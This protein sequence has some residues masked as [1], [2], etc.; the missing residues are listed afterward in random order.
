M[1]YYGKR[2]SRT[3]VLFA[4][5]LAS[6]M[7][8]AVQTALLSESAGYGA[9]STESSDTEFTE[10]GIGSYSKAV[11]WAITVST[12]VGVG[13]VYALSVLS[14]PLQGERANWPRH[15]VAN[16]I[17]VTLMVVGVVGFLV[18]PWATTTQH[19]RRLCCGGVAFCVASLLLAAAAVSLDLWP[20][21]LFAL[22]GIGGVTRTT[23]A[24]VEGHRTCLNCFVW[25]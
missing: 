13:Y 11:A 1:L 4:L 12:G 9:T 15:V 7:S 22:G 20:L 5:Q 10:T 16:S 8:G 14:V 21:F 23:T 25:L 19:F 17:T 3:F 6:K 24:V 2:Q 18:S